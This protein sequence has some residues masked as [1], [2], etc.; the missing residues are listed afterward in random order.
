MI[1]RGNVLIFWADHVDRHRVPGYSPWVRGL[2]CCDEGSS[3]DFVQGAFQ[4]MEYL[5]GFRESP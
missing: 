1:P 3:H 2:L 5:M 4:L